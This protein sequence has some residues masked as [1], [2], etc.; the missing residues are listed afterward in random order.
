MPSPFSKQCISSCLS[1]VIALP[2]DGKEN[3]ERIAEIL[4]QMHG[5]DITDFG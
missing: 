5:W 2:S 3:R 4:A 1:G